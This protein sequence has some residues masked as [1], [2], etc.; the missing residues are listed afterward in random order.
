MTAKTKGILLIALSGLMFAL[1]SLLVKLAGDL[2]PMQKAFFR[3][4]VAMAAAAAL[5]WKSGQGFHFER[6][7]LP[8]LLLRSLMGTIGVVTNFYAIDHMLIADATM[9]QKLG[10]FFTVLFSAFLLKERVTFAQLAAV[11][12]AFGG[13]LLIVK[14]GFVPVGQLL[15]AA[16]AFASALTSGLAYAMVRKLRLAGERGPVI[17]FFF[18]AFSCITLLPFSLLNYHPMSPAQLLSLMAAGVCAALAQFS[19]TASYACAPSRVT[20]VFNYSQVLFAG[21]LAFWV[22]GQVPDAVSLLGYAV[23]LAVAV[24]TFVREEHGASHSAV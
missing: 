4:L 6:R 9:I 1:M 15:P 3:N 24:V 8:D 18:S 20:A 11:A 5:L 10:P 23:I 19:L 21:L 14:P 22:F 2:P 13:C 17:V 16:A 12:V 7:N